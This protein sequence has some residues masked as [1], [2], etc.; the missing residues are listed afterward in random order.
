MR[1]AIAAL[2]DLPLV[3]EWVPTAD[4]KGRLFTVVPGMRVEL[5]QYD[6]WEPTPG[7]HLFDAMNR[8][9]YSAKEK[10]R[11]QR[12]AKRLRERLSSVPFYAKAAERDGPGY[13]YDFYLSRVNE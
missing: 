9:A 8:V 10:D 3:T 7:E 2:L 11:R 4:G 13:W 1:P 5:D 12:G 6:Q